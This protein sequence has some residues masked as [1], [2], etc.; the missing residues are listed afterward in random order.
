[1]SDKRIYQVVYEGQDRAVSADTLV[2]M[3]SR[4]LK[5]ASILESIERCLSKLIEVSVAE[6]KPETK[7][8]KVWLGRFNAQEKGQDAFYIHFCPTN[9]EYKGGV[10]Y[11]QCDIAEGYFL[12]KEIYFRRDL[13]RDTPP[14]ITEEVIPFLKDF[15]R[16][17][18]FV[19]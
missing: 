5:E 1:M 7:R 2:E 11:L 13:P 6:S 15:F 10:R 17:F 9:E 14:Y 19:V 16:K 4:F 18:D 8:G 12:K 3:V